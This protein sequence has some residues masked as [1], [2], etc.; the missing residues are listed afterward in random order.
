VALMRHR[1]GAMPGDGVTA[2]ESRIRNA[3]GGD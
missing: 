2:G 1:F 3:A